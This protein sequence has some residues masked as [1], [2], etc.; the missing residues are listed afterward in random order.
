[1]T[2]T[3]RRVALALC[4]ALAAAAGLAGAGQAQTP[5]TV[6]V[7]NPSAITFMPM[8]AAIGEGY[9]EE[10][11]LDITIETVDGSSSVLQVLSSGQAQIGAPGPGPVLAARARDVDVVFFYNLYPK[12][13]FGLMVKD[14]SPVQAPEDLKGT[15]IGIG[16]ADGAE[17]S[18]TRAI[19]TDLG[20]SEGTD[21]T[22]LPVGDGGTATV[23]FMRDEVAAYAA[24]VSDA[25]IMKNRGLV[26]REITPEQYLA[27]FGNG[28][29]AMREYIEAN[30]AVIE[31]FGRAMVRGMKFAL[32][33]AN[34]DATLAHAAVGNP[35][36]GEDKAFAASLLA[37]AMERMTPTDAFAAQ[38]FGYLPPEHWE[39][40]H[41]SA[42]ASG[43]LSAPLPDLTAA[44]TN[45]FVAGWNAE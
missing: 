35:S 25:A 23:A 21:Y 12:S 9:F 33:P 32:D 31:G 14:E 45:D 27:F 13:V 29:A 5:V 26:L 8:W 28:F 37:A 38:G 4:A 6:V 17:A 3:T 7:P 40:W 15:V 36:E 2:A 44:Y 34:V 22:F 1:M 30:P 10:E 11:G 16:T 24:A 39:M 20:L 19:L 43:A 42:Q 41:E 18:F